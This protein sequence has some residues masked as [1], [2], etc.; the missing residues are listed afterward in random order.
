M[1]A[2]H[3]A[4][5]LRLSVRPQVFVFGRKHVLLCFDPFSLILGSQEAS[6]IDFDFFVGFKSG[7]RME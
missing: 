2:L 3:F 5:P 6:Y 1:I 4:S 7:R